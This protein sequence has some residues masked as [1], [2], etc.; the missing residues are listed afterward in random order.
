MCIDVLGDFPIPT[1]DA[2]P[3]GG[4]C[5]DIIIQCLILSLFGKSHFINQIL[6]TLLLQL[7]ETN[8]LVN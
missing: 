3:V 6:G 2:D 1:Q 8:E 4:F 7:Y 5:G